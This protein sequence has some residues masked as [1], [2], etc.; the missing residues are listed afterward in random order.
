MTSK[1][2]DFNLLIILF[3]LLLSSMLFAHG[4]GLDQSGGHNCYVGSCAGSYHYH[5]GSSNNDI[6]WFFWLVIIGGAIY[7]V[8]RFK[9]NSG[10][11]LSNHD[12]S[13]QTC[14]KGNELES[15]TTSDYVRLEAVD[16]EVGERFS[17]LDV[18]EE[19][20]LI[21]KDWL[22]RKTYFEALKVAFD[23]EQNPDE[24]WSQWSE[25][26]Q[27][28]K[29]GDEIWEYDS[30]SEYWDSLAGRAGFVIVR[31]DKIIAEITTMEN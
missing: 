24:E 16:E 17:P 26:K 5:R 15:K 27:Q 2:I 28:Y 3:Y 22:I 30:P 10:D 14:Q 25:F 13:Y 29:A 12:T 21:P 19:E 23:N 20:E 18:Y 11:N 7:L 8:S 1:F 31:N 9:N 4:G 6:G